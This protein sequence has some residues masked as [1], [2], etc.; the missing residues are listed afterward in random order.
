M[1]DVAIV[2]GGVLGCAL[3]AFLA[4]AGAS[5]RLHERDVL[6]AGA[7]G[8]NSGVL[9]HP[10]DETLEPLYARSLEH[11]AGLDGFALP[12]ESVGCLVLGEDPGPLRAQADAVAPGFP[13]LRFDWLDPDD[14]AREEPGLAPDLYAFRMATGRPVPPAGAVRAFAERA[15]AAG[16]VLLEGSGARLARDGDRVTGVETAAGFEP[17]GAVVIAAGPWS[18]ELGLPLPVTPLWGVVAQVRLA[19]PPRHVLEEAGTE[20]LVAAEPPAT[21]LFSLITLD[22]T[23]SLGSSFDAVEPD[24]GAV[25]HD[26]RARGARFVPALADAELGPLRRCARPLSPDGRPLL[27]PVPGV[28]RLHVASGHGP[29]GVTLGP[30]SA[31]LV[32]AAVLD[33]ASAIA[34]ELDVARVL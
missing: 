31:E 21:R 13:S 19:A 3:A 1:A 28:D 22:G 14:L 7:S 11:Y 9:E 18:G 8:R 24:P 32:A 25:A 17:A 12:P 33:P 27:G 30:A 20:S 5:V 34:P 15:R 4:E 16:A 2:G 10:L 26:L 6:G 29:W 23:S